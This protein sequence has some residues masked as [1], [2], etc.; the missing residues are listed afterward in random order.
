MR[1][2]ILGFVRTTLVGGVVFLLPVVLIV[3]IARQVFALA[4]KVSKPVAAIM[5]DA[6]DGAFAASLAT[7]FILLVAAFA[8]GLFARTRAGQAMFQWLENGLIGSLP[9]FNFVRGIA[10]S[11]DDTG[12]QGVH[13]VLVPADAGLALGFVFEGR[14]RAWV[15]VFLP[16]APQWTSGSI[17]FAEAA[18]VR[19]A[20]IGFAKA[21]VVLKRLGA[22]SLAV[23]TALELPGGSETAPT[24]VD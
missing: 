10:D 18:N 8:A 6:V 11:I 4:A 24:A 13:V 22:N 21:I 2:R 15:P 16:G 17:V 9:Q 3:W 20:G 12:N 1:R 5:P 23:S 19:D 14:E 7:I